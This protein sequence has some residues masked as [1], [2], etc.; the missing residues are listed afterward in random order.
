MK[1][2]I[3]CIIILI[4]FASCYSQNANKIDSDFNLLN[5]HFS[6][7]NYPGDSLSLPLIHQNN[8]Y[9][10]Q[11]ADQSLHLNKK[12][13]KL[14]NPFSGGNFPLAFSLLYNDQLVSLFDNGRFACHNITNFKRNL[15]LEEKLNT[16]KFDYAWI[17]DG[18][19]IA[20]YNYEYFIFTDD[21]KWSEY[22]KPVPFCNKNLPFECKSK[23]FED[24]KYLVYQKC[25]G[26]WG[27]TVYFYNKESEKPI[28]LEQ[29]ALIQ[30]LKKTVHTKYCHTRGLL[31]YR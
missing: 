25:Q 16:R 31:I 27:E 14:S 2:L 6:E 7:N 4:T 15:E 13:I 21:Q 3:S 19:I 18:S 11:F 28:K 8:N 1:K 12:E 26:E 9:S 22:K 24:N 23:L 30:S 5:Q 10:I 17:I 29:P 20:K